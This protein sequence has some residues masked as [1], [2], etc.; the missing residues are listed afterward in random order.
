MLK[1]VIRN[2]GF[3]VLGLLAGTGLLSPERSHATDYATIEASPA[4]W[5]IEADG[6]T[7]HL[8]GTFH[9][10]PDALNW[11]SDI[12]NAAFDEADTLWLEADVLSAEAQARMQALIPQLG[13]NPQGV[14]LSSLLGADIYAA[15]EAQTAELGVPAGNFEPVQP[16]LAGI[17]LGAMQLQSFGFNPAMG[18]EAVLSAQANAQGKSIGYLET[19]EGQLRILADLPMDIQIEWLRVSLDEMGDLRG[20]LDRMVT[21]WATGD[22]DMLDS[23]VNGSIRNA[24]PELY[25]ALMV[26]RNHDWVPHIEAMLTAGGTHFVAVGAGHM[27]GDDGVVALLQAQGHTVTR[28]D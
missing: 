13:L 3:A 22:M 20:E 9:L 18:V 1:N 10:L 15:F 5:T 11:R 17:T 19:A 7:V 6:A 24:S 26:N 21:A 16:W 23:Q 4:L 28:R 12:V 25:E 14:T 27:P 8:L 2:A